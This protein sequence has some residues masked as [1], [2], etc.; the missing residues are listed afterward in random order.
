MPSSPLSLIASLNVARALV[1]PVVREALRRSNRLE[2]FEDESLASL[3]E[4]R[5][6]SE[7]ERNFVS[8]LVHGIYAADSRLL[9]SRFL[10][11]SLRFNNHFSHSLTTVQVS[12][13]ASS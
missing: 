9:S 5:F 7:F 8:A 4:R 3:M 2:P 10:P 11:V 12:D 1:P 6:G 13:I